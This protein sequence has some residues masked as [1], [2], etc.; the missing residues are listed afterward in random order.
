[1]MLCAVLLNIDWPN[2]GIIYGDIGGIISVT[3]LRIHA[4]K[5]Y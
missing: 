2:Y 1:M 5:A 4:R 3:P